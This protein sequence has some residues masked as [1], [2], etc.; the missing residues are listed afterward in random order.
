MEALNGRRVARASEPRLQ[1]LRHV[2][3]GGVAD[4]HGAQALAGPVEHQVH[5]GHEVALENLLPGLRDDGQATVRVNL[6]AAES[7]EVFADGDDL[8]ALEAVEVGA[9]EQ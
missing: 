8:P 3:E 9:R 5:E 2:G 1:E 7:G 6:R 4:H